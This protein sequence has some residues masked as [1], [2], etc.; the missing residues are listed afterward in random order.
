MA[1]TNLMARVRGAR[2]RVMARAT[3]A[4]IDATCASDARTIDRAMLWQESRSSRPARHQDC[5]VGQLQFAR[6]S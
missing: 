6:R 2:D 3:T 1:T 4:C 5:G